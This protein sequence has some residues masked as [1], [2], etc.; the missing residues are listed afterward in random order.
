M[1]C[2]KYSHEIYN[3]HR[4]YINSLGIG[5]LLAMIRPAFVSMSHKYIK[6]ILLRNT[7]FLQLCINRDN[8]DYKKGNI[9]RRYVNALPINLIP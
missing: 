1:K 9:Y 2:Y 8:T 5:R 3:Y 7:I 4:G 6:Y